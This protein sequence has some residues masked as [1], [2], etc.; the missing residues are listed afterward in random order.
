MLSGGPISSFR[1][2]HGQAGLT[3]AL[4]S[5]EG[6]G[7]G[8]AQLDYTYQNPFI[9]YGGSLAWASPHYATTSLAATADRTTQLATVFTGLALGSHANLTVSYTASRLRDS[10][11]RDIAALTG[12]MQLSRRLDLVASADSEYGSA[13]I[14]NHQFFVSLNYQVGRESVAAVSQ[15]GGSQGA[16]SGVSL[17]RS[18]P[19]GTGIGYLFSH[20]TGSEIHDN[21]YF[22]VQTSTGLYQASYF[23]GAGGAGQTEL[24]ASGGLVDA[25]DGL[26][27][28]RAVDDG[29]AVIDT[30]GVG[31]V[32]GYFNNQLAGRTDRRGRLLIP[33]LL[34]YYGNRVEIADQ[35]IPMAYSVGTTEK[36][37]APPYRGGALVRFGVKRE[38]AVTG[39]VVVAANTQHVV[40]AFGELHMLV[41][42]HQVVAE[43][44]AE[45][46]FY[47]EDVSAG[48]YTAQIEYADG[49]CTAEFVVPRAAGAVTSL[50]RVTC[51]PAQLGSTVR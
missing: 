33:N 45:G 49:S 5:S 43:L 31:G 19:L 42:A 23:N 4:S 34:S 22:Q 16:G 20:G 21:D 28:T 24:L 9:S 40:P 18:L 47:L 27:L 6:F 44:N 37:V 12:S 7:G 39:T 41:G 29:F 36:T 3:A 50:G 26:M 46:T 1:L 10:G 11:T 25:G 13:T 14:A 51:A 17:E 15:Q 30:D 8:A 2:G 38:T 32:R 35:D 48:R